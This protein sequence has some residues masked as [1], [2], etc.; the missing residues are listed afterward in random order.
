MHPPRKRRLLLALAGASMFFATPA[1][2]ADV[3]FDLRIERGQVPEKQRRLRVNEGD[4]VHLRF[5][6]DRPLTLHMHGYDIER[7]VEPEQIA[8]MDFAA[9]ATGRFPLYVHDPTG[10]GQ[11]HAEALLLYV[12]VYPR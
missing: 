4:A 10:S 1:Q 12:E 3:V 2:A 8:T 11:G 9:H 6:T 7:R 5:S